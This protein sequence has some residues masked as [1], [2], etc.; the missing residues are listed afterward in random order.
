MRIG[1]ITFHAPH[2]RGS[3]L[4][5]FAIQ[6]V[7]KE[8]NKNGEVEIIDFSNTN[9]RDMYAL[10]RKVDSI[11]DFVLNLLKVLYYKPF[12]R[13]F[14]EFERFSSLYLN[15]SKQKF[16]KT[17]ELSSLDGK[18]DCIIAGSDQIWN[19]KCYDAD[20]AYYCGAFVKTPKIAYAPSFGA[21]DINLLS[22]KEKYR[23][24]INAF[25]YISIRENN[26]KKEIKKLTGKDV[27]VLLDPT[28]LLSR[29][30]WNKLVL[31]DLPLPDK[32]IFF[33]S[34]GYP[35]NVCNFVKSFSNQFGLPVVM[36]DVKNWAIRGRGLGFNLCKYGG[37]N[38]FLTC[39]KNATLVFTSSF[40]GTVFSAIF[41]KN[42]LYLD[43]GIR[44]EFDDRVMSILSE[45]G[46]EA[47]LI[48]VD[49]DKYIKY[50][51]Q[52]DYKPI[53]THIEK[54]ADECRAWLKTAIK[55]VTDQC[56]D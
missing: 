5:A 6:S 44:S 55:N 27:N 29:Q 28:L 38:A 31:K 2:N 54:K 11:K 48:N 43:D 30:E 25:S 8:I 52:I 24:W 22:D 20:T 12:K 56:L 16:I 26:G 49:K 42:F 46:L 10:F 23:D 14:D 9:Q 17:E 41:E 39:I 32:Y 35:R 34:F 4:Q 21:N 47:R 33:Y 53:K 7:L 13:Y 15:K 18:Y 3:M 19:T 45:F 51:K 1:I 40:H 50:P 36:M 37:P